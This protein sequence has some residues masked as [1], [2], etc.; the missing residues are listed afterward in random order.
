MAKN[1]KH[2]KKFVCPNCRDSLY[3]SDNIFKCNKCNKVYNK[4]KFGFFDFIIDHK[5]YEF[6][7]TTNEY[8]EIQA[9]R[10]KNLYQKFLKPYL[11]QDFCQKVL[12]V[13]C[14]IGEVVSLLLE[15]GYEAYGIDLP[16]VSKFWLQLGIDFQHFF[17]CDATSLPFVDN[18]FD[19]IY[20]LGVIEHIGTIGGHCTLLDN[21][22]EIRKKYARELL[23]IIKP[24]GRILIS[25]PNKSFPIDFQHGAKDDYSQ[26]NLIM[27]IRDYIFKK[28][29]FNIH[30]T[31]GKNHLLS[32]SE[33]KRLFCYEG[34]ACHFEPLPLKNYFGFSR[35]Q[36]YLL[37]HLVGLVKIYLDHIPKCLRSS[38]LNPYVLVQ[39]KK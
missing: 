39:I 38:F 10:S 33:I 5:M 8:A 15:Y 27:N 7:T 25:C 11:Q 1:T 20:S 3:F 28:T 14:G 36:H 19:A 23:R 6:D 12:D 18:Y 24:G 22:W 35:F 4:N 2:F 21:Y 17:C 32:Y 37:N 31:W 16:N 9:L 26:N 13:G 29:N 30:A 34:G